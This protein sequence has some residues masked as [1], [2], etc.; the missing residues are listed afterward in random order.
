MLNKNWK[1]GKKWFAKMRTEIQRNFVQEPGLKGLPE[2]YPIPF[3]NEDLLFY[4]QRNHNKN[5]IVYELNRT[6]SGEINPS[7]PM[8]VYWIQYMNGG[9]M[10]ELNYFQ[11]KLAYG[12]NSR[13]ISSDVFQFHF[14][15][16][17]QLKLFI[18]K[19][20]EERYQTICKI[21]GV[22]SVL[23]N[24]YVYAEELGVFPKV[25]FIELYGQQLETGIFTYEKIAIES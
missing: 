1:K 16:Y 24:I 12:Y 17:D 2:D 3:E 6:S 4:I 10:S 9:L 23:S 22:M 13:V 7:C 20:E 21:N 18:V 14:V 19:N 8:H 15:S 11:N 25:E 5:T